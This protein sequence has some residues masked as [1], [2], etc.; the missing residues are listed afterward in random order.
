MSVD[1]DVDILLYASDTGCA[2]HDRAADYL[3]RCAA[4]GQVVR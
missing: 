4:D 3:R 1:I 2:E